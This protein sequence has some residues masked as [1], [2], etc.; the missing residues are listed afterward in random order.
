[1]IANIVSILTY[2]PSRPGVEYCDMIQVGHGSR[3]RVK[4]QC[5]LQAFDAK[6][7]PAGV[8]TKK[9]LA[10]LKMSNMDCN[11]LKKKYMKWKK[12]HSSHTLRMLF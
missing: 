10:S 3:G 2:P 1:M 8:V 11:D 4:V 7:F 6:H 9:Y 5:I 12:F